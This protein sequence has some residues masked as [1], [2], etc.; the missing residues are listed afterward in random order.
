[1]TLDASTFR[2]ELHTRRTFSRR[3]AR[4]RG[5]KEKKRTKDAN[6][7]KLQV[8]TSAC[9][10][11]KSCTC[12]YG[13]YIMCIYEPSSIAVLWPWRVCFES[14]HPW[15]GAARQTW[16]SFKHFQTQ[17]VCNHESKC[18]MFEETCTHLYN[19]FARL[20]FVAWPA[21]NSPL[22]NTPLGMS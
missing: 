9:W 18:S 21:S 20:H 7:S 14:C 8:K 22:Q 17:C 12:W 6:T 3:T 15:H 2:L 10:W 13:K 19:I 11:T 1:M 5:Q 16:A 4:T